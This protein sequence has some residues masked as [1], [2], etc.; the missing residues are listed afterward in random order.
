VDETHGIVLSPELVLVDPELA[1]LVRALPSRRA[2]WEVA[3]A[4]RPASVAAF[5]SQ[6][7]RRPLLLGL[8][9][10]LNVA[11]LVVL[12]QLP[13]RDAPTLVTTMQ[14]PTR[15]VP[16]TATSSPKMSQPPSVLHVHPTLRSRAALRVLAQRRVF[17]TVQT[18]PRLRRAFV[19]ATTGL[20]YNGLAVS[21]RSVSRT[22]FACVVQ[23]LTNGRRVSMTVH[24]TVPAT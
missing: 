2:R 20:P 10:A 3:P 19:D 17:E 18:T 24:V 7:R 13:S 9:L 11:L 21:C 4:A 22:A 1:E 15:P 14:P 8:S 23:R 12:T 6:P 5:V 16:Q